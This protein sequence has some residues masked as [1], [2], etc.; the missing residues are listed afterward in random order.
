V[1]LQAVWRGRIARQLADGRRRRQHEVLKRERA[2]AAA[3]LADAT[4]TR[5]DERCRYCQMN[6]L[7]AVPSTT[8]CSASSG[9]HSNTNDNNCCRSCGDRLPAGGDFRGEASTHLKRIVVSQCIDHVF[10]HA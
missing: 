3:K 8:D 2:L 4:N 10:T 1:Q 9:R 7:A 5:D 6:N